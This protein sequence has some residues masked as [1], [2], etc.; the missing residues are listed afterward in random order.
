MQK[1]TKQNNGKYVATVWD[2]TYTPTGKKH[3]K[4]LYSTKSSKDLEKKVKAYEEAVKSRNAI[5]KRNITFLEYAKQWAEIYK[6]T[7]ALNTKTM[8][9]NIIDNHLSHE[10][11]VLL[12]DFRAIHLINILNHAEG[13]KRTQQ[14]ILMTT[15]QIIKQAVNDRLYTSTDAEDL[16]N[17]FP[18]IVYRANEKRPLTS[19]EKKAV[20]TANLQPMDKAFLYLIYGCGL[21]R[22]EA[23]A[24]YKFDFNWK[25]KEV[26]IDKAHIMV[27]SETV[28]KETKSVNGVR[29]VPI[30]DSTRHYLEEY[31]KGCKT[32]RLFT[33]RNGN[34]MT[35]S[36][37]DKMWRRILKAL[38]EVSDEPIEELT[39]HVFRHNYTTEL[40]YQIPALSIKH[41]ARLIGDT[42]A[43]VMKVYA[44]VNLER[45]DA[46]AA[47]NS[48][49][50]M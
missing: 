3:R 4:Y 31:V 6:S 20:F 41:I 38:N 12:S 29:V 45:E 19:A 48:A 10:P 27:K 24:L 40:C 22:E 39:A 2:G 7:T 47:I 9:T 5:Q 18:K 33:L 42:E 25:K 17:V 16:F 37:Y 49:F 32:S 26:T 1:Y 43:V 8:Y 44:H 23:L 50:N 35:K 13:K 11:A 21:R 34:P 46:H 28:E 30:P 14:Q 15:K 36:S